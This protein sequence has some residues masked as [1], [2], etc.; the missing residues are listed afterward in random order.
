MADSVIIN[1]EV[2]KSDMIGYGEDMAICPD[3]NG[4]GYRRIDAEVYYRKLRRDLKNER[5]Q[6]K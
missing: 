3:C 5:E 1:C 4:K 6:N 2:C